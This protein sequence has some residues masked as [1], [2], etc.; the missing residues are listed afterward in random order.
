LLLRGLLDQWALGEAMGLD[1]HHRIVLAQT[2]GY[3]AA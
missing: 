2:V 1:A 3:P